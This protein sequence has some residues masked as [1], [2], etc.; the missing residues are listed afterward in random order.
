V[1]IVTSGVSAKQLL[2]RIAYLSGALGLYWR[3]RHRETLTVVMFHRVLPE[4]D[5]RFS[6]ADP[7]YTMRLDVFEQCARWLK[8]SY[9]MV[10][11]EEVEASVAGKGRLPPHAL[12]V[13]FDDG[14]ED[15]ARYAVPALHALGIPCAVFIATNGIENDLTLWKDVAAT[16]WRACA[17]KTQPPSGSP[18]ELVDWLGSLPQGERQA[19]LSAAAEGVSANIRPLMMTAAQVKALAQSGAETGAHGATHRPLTEIDD[20]DGEALLSRQEL[21]VLVGGVATSFAYPHGCHSPKTVEAVARAGFGVQFT[22]VSCLNAVAGGR[23]GSSV[24]GRIDIPESEI[25]DTRGQFD[26]WR[27]AFWVMTREVRK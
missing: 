27:M 26:A 18:A 19:W 5:H 22:S 1:G 14:W 15:T 9:A 7:D 16:I 17:G 4:S 8:G 21:K 24:L 6:S 3:M 10:S 11:L 23:P 20:V 2:K 25:V 13:T 12:L